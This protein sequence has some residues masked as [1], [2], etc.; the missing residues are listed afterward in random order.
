MKFRVYMKDPDGVY[1]SIDD[2]VQKSVRDL[3][4][5]PK[6]RAAVAEERHDALRAACR[7]WFE[8]GEY[9]VVEVDTEAKTCRVVPC[10]E[11]K[12]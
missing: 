5:S 6:E 4:L 3:P 8:H 11:A 7:E 12:E 10:S 2:A 1:E 9:L